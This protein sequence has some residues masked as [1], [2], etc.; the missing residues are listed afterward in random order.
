MSGVSTL[1]RPT[2]RREAY[3]RNTPDPAKVVG[4]SYRVPI[5][6]QWYWEL[7]TVRRKKGIRYNSTPH[8]YPPILFGFYPAST[9][10]S[11]TKK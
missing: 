2:S 9:I 10:A 1:P 4:A 7:N 6:Q 3:V 11:L 5:E 8:G